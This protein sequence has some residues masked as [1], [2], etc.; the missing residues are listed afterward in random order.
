MNR[1]QVIQAM[2]DTLAR[3][4]VRLMPEFGPASHVHLKELLAK[5]KNKALDLDQLNR[6]LGY[7]QGIAV[8]SGSMSLDDA[9]RINQRAKKSPLEA[10]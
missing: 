3:A 7:M 8:A 9:K 1:D 5:A 6:W 4:S 2:E 10:G